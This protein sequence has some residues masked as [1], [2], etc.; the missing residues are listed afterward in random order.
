MSPSTN[1]APSMAPTDIRNPDAKQ[2]VD[3]AGHLN[4]KKLTLRRDEWPTK[5]TR[6]NLPISRLRGIE[7][8]FQI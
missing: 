2:L 8:S 1:N 4:K 5:A 7:A 6:Q 3:G